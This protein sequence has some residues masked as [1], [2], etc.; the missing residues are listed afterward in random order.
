MSELAGISNE[1]LLAA[2]AQKKVQAG[3]D[4]GISGSFVT[5]FASDEAE[6]VRYMAS[7]LYPNEPIERAVQRFGKKDGQIV[8]MAD[9]GK[10]YN[11]LPAGWSPRALMADVARGAGK[12]IP[13]GAGAAA[14]MATLPLATTGIGLAGTMAAAGGA[15]AGGEAVRQKIGDYLMG[16]ASTGNI[17]VGQVVQEGAASGFGQGIGVGFNALASRGAVK[18]IARF[19][20]VATKQA[21]KEAADVGVD[22]TPA[23]ATGLPSLA[24]QQKRLTN[25][26]ATSNEMRDFYT[27]RNRQ[28]LRAWSDFM[29]N[30]SLRA[31][32]EDVG[33]LAR[34]AARDV[35]KNLKDKMVSDATP[36]YRQ[37]FEE[38][39]KIIWSPE[40]E[41]LSGSP[42]VRSAMQGAVRIWKDKAIADGF[43]SMNPGAMVENGILK[44]PGGSPPAFP[45]LQFWDYTKRVL[46]DQVKSALVAGKNDKARTLTI[47]TQSLRNE[48]DK[49][50][51]ESYKV[52]RNIYSE[53]A[54][55][56]STAM[57]SA[58]K[59]L[60]DTKDVNILSAAR[61]VFDPRARS[62]QMIGTLRA[63]LEKQDPAAWQGLKRLYIQDVTTDALRIAEQGDV[64]NRAGKIF[65]AFA[66][67]RVEENLKAA[68]T[69]QEY[70]R[71]KE[72]LA[73]FRRAGSVP[74]LRSDTEFNRLMTEEAE[75][76]ARPLTSKIARNINPAQALRSLDE[77]MT[78]RSLDRNASRLVDLV[79]TSDPTVI[80]G[81]KELRRLPLASKEFLIVLG[82]VLGQGGK[83]GATAVLSD[84]SDRQPYQNSK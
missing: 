3:R 27:A 62:P 31:D 19:D 21:Y 23:E 70:G 13:V 60:A 16:P 17:D 51:P 55:D 18:D 66:N 5:G 1:A 34:G 25:I 73:V 46:D 72:I 81:M 2:I 64:L 20:P 75:A 15:A 47:I 33:L 41:R 10:V 39:D 43:G 28:V 6:A 79:T 37:A 7:Q 40:L 50:G 77:F 84:Q 82:H 48:L 71:M 9:D 68:M 63:A 76:Q 11:A 53:G 65:K 32:A 59:I 29:D 61:H 52:A 26:T 56:L 4:I 74:A 80:E 45:N 44:F 38:G 24:A 57:Q 83:L 30:V 14:G 8:H 58:M 54:E 36:F 69:P 42:S 49:I 35:L 12:A 78:E 22:I 67:P